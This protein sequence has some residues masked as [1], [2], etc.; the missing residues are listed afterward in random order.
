MIF[1]LPRKQQ[2]PM[3]MLLTWFITN[4][5]ISALDMDMEMELDVGQPESSNDSRALRRNHNRRRKHHEP[6]SQRKFPWSNHSKQSK[7]LPEGIIGGS[8]VGPGK[9]PWFARGTFNNQNSWWG[10]GGSL[11]TPEFVLSAAHCQWDT[12]GGF[13]IGALCSPYGPSAGSNCGQ[14]VEEFDIKKVYDHPKYNDGTLNNDF[15]LIRLSGK[16][17]ITPV[18]MD[19]SDISSN[20]SPGKILYPIG[21]GETGSGS[22][23]KLKDVAVP[24]VTN[25]KCGSL[26]GGGITNAMMC[27]GDTN[28]GG[29]DACQGDSGGPLYDSSSDTLVGVT[30]WG[31]GC[32]LK[33]YPGVYSRISDEWE[34]IKSTICDNH[35]SPKPD[36]C[37]SGPS[38]N[39]PSPTPPS[40]TP[41]SPTPPSPTPPTQD[42]ATDQELF[43]FMM[44]TDGFG[45][46]ITWRLKKRN[47]KGK[48]KNVLSGGFSEAYGDN[49]LFTE[50]YCIPKNDCY[51]FL[52][53]DSYGDGLCC[54]EGEGYYKISFKD[55][56]VRKNK[57]KGKRK[58]KTGFGNC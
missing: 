23:N 39:P 46:D 7:V 41:P 18:P 55:E 48:F 30:S 21:F 52:I 1:T 51:K 24:Y 35:S 53:Y 5:G 11:V 42:C 50:E 56:L 16:S 12:S 25:S 26:Y 29:E 54:N 4:H 9:Y 19:V 2:L 31:N 43:E 14:K 32:A 58:Q 20:Y 27:A 47:S 22:S 10:C 38:P 57:F 44:Q 6:T 8:N 37:G 45:E 3:V 36:F 40:P 34:W 17:S 49:N 13:Q 28:N 15:S 33:D